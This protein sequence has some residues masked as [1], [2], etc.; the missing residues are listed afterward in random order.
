MADECDISDHMAKPATG[1]AMYLISIQIF[2]RAITFS[3]NQILLL[4]VSPEALGIAMQLELYSITVLHFSRE[5]IRVAAQTEPQH[6]QEAKKKERSGNPGKIIQDELWKDSPPNSASQALVNMSYLAAIFG[7]LMLY[8][9]GFLYMRVASVNILNAP[10]F[11]KSLALVGIATVLELFAEPCFAVVQHNMLYQSRAAIETVS[12]LAKGLFSC[13]TAFWVRRMGLDRGP[14]PYA[15]GQV[16]YGLFIFCGYFIVAKRLTGKGGFSLLPACLSK[17]QYLSGFISLPLLYRSASI[18]FQSV[19]K[20]LLTQGDTMILTALSTLEDQGLYALAS[21]YGGLV[22]RLV[23]QPIEESSRTAFGRWLPS[24]KPRIAKPVS[25]TFAR[26]HLQDMLHAYFL[27]TIVSWAL[28]PLLLPVALRVILNSRW[29]L[30]NIQEPLLAYCYYIPFLAFNG[31]T[32]AFVSSAASNSE[33]RAQASWMGACSLAFAFAAYFL[34]K[35]ADLG[36]RGLVWA[37]I[38]N[39]ALRILWSFR[40]IQKY[41]GKHKQELRLR[42]VLPRRE[43]CAVGI[44]TWSCTLALHTPISTKTNVAGAFFAGAIVTITIK[45]F[46]EGANHPLSNQ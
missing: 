15:I 32:E 23:F 2:S 33:L 19:V 16:A 9:F 41:F 10:Y 24:R 43:T 6:L 18:F 21:N 39:M 25:V 30:L 17:E 4:H 44:V 31:I 42:D 36:V 11:N 13:G 5:S 8:I 12:A 28:G 40:F 1:G 26:S 14:L 46:S 20:H 3:A 27:L 7:C 38:F 34:L 45:K 22:A 29:A 35:V 37:N